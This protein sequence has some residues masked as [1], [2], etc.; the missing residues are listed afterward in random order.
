[1]NIEL[2]LKINSDG[3]TYLN[4]WDGVHGHDVCTEIVN[5]KMVDDNGQ[6]LS[7]VDF[8]G[9]VKNIVD[10]NNEPL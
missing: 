10:S 7:L 2:E 3:K 8:I 1:M 6:Q 5:G 4:F 9:R